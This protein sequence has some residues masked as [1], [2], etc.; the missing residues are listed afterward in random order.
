[1]S[2]LNSLEALGVPD[3]GGP[4][5]ELA[6]THRSF[7]F[8]RPEPI[9]HNERL[10]FLGDTILGAI[11][12]DLIYRTLPDVAEGDLARLRASLVNTHA[13]ARV[14]RRIGVGDHI[15]LGKGEEASG[16]RDKDSLLADTLEALIGA[17][18]LGQGMDVVREALERVFG[19]LMEETLSSGSAHDAKTV[20]QEMV[21][22]RWSE[23]PTYRVASSGPDHDKRFMAHV[24]IE[25]ELFG[26]GSG[27]SKKEAEQHAAREAL[28]RLELDH[29]DESEVASDARAS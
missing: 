29:V 15:K 23:R 14:A 5:Y 22:R 26:A 28:E 4:L 7:A 6:L 1:M 12:T 10:E 18:Y 25:G 16:G 27:R 2:R 21:V 24:Y 17:V 20:L 3:D 8:E 9:E 11:V 13:L 19:E